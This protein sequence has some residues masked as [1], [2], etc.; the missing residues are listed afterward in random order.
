MSGAVS[1]WTGEIIGQLFLD[2]WTSTHHLPTGTW[3]ETLAALAGANPQALT[4]VPKDHPALGKTG[5]Q[6]TPDA[7][8]IRYHIISS[9]DGAFQLIYDG[10]DK[11]PYTADDQVRSFPPDLVVP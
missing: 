6:P 7:P 11:L 4:L 8:A 3:E 2:Y 10:P 9:R 5:F 1:G